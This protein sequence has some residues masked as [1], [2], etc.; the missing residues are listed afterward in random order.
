MILVDDHSLP[1]IRMLF[2][3][4]GFSLV[5][6]WALEEGSSGVVLYGMLS[7]GDRKVDAHKHLDCWGKFTEL[8]LCGEQPFFIAAS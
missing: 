6:F 3:V 7:H 5:L 2:L 8:A 1:G 4:F